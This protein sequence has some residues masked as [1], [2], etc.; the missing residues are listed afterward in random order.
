MGQVKILYVDDEVDL[1]DLA[2]SFF[3]DEGLILETSSDFNVALSLIQKHSYDLVITDAKMPTGSGYDLIKYLRS[4]QKFQGKI[5]LATGS[6]QDA[7][8]SAGYDIVVQKPIDF[9]NLIDTVKSMLNI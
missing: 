5:I 3:E 8:G 1:L 4:D 7:G 2:A 9:L 6:L